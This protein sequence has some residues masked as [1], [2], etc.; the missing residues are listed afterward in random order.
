MARPTDPAKL[1]EYRA[2]QAAA[3]RRYRA[4][5]RAERAGVTPPP[6][7]QPRREPR[8]RPPTG[9]GGVVQRAASYAESVRERRT[10]TLENLPQARNPAANIRVPRETPRAEPEKKR[11]DARARQAAR[12]REQVR[13]ESPIARGR[14][15]KGSIVADAL[16]AAEDG[17]LSAALRSRVR[18]AASRIASIPQQALGI[19]LQA[20]G[21]GAEVDEILQ[22]LRY[23][24]DEGPDD[25][26]A[27]LES[28]ADLADR[29]NAL[30]G[31]KAVGNLRL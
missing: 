12:I 26:V 23:H 30:Y 31:P 21:G 16:Q 29:A 25:H 18:A 9:R 3:A 24:G 19:L 13:A 22:K 20:E 27:R 4:R 14:A 7:V 2:K 15:F 8:Y 6:E 11:A 10:R 28:F 17:G 1:A 5:Q